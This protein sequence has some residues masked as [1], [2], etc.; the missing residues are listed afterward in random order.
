MTWYD[1]SPPAHID[2]MMSPHV[3]DKCVGGGTRLY[4]STLAFNTFDHWGGG[5]EGE[6]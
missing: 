4:P 5:R 1:T 6:G 2:T 3:V